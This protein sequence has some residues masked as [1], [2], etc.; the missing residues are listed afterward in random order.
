MATVVGF[1]MLNTRVQS[2]L[3]LTM[4]KEV[5]VE[6]LREQL[7]NEVDLNVGFGAQE[8]A[9]LKRV[10]LDEDRNGLFKRAG[11]P[12][13]ESLT[14]YLVIFAVLLLLAEGYMFLVLGTIFR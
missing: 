9:R 14:P 11:F 13:K 7:V 1:W 2:I 5:S 12:R 8:Q 10:I 3:D 6:E 4:Q